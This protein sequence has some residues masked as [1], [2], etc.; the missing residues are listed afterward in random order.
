MRRW[1]ILAVLCGG[2]LAY[3]QYVPNPQPNC[4]NYWNGTQYICGTPSGTSIPS[5]LIAI[6]L[7]SCPSG[8]TEVSALN[9]KMLRGTV[10]ANGDVGTTGG[11][12][13]ITPTGIV[14]QPTLAINAY[15][16]VGTVTA[17]TFTGS[18]GATSA[19]SAGTPAGTNSTATVATVSGNKAGTSSGAFSTI[20]GSSPGSNITVPAETF[21]GS[22]MATHTHTLTPAGTNSVPTFTGTVATMTGTVTQPT[23]TGTPLDPSPPYLKVIFCS[24]N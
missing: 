6:S 24:K 21:T 17:P 11:N 10:A 12:A 19:T 14:S 20:G 9:G 22:V 3:G 8:W 15:T 1:L 2:S 4:M 5:G 7:T 23:F 13:M 16:P 18:Q